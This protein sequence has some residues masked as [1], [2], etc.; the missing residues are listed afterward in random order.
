MCGWAGSKGFGRR[1]RVVVVEASRRDEEEAEEGTGGC[2]F[3]LVIDG[4]GSRAMLE[5]LIR[6]VEGSA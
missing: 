2:V 6:P 1:A 3:V 4:C 5:K